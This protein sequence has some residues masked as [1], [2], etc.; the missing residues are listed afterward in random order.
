MNSPYKTLNFFYLND[1]PFLPL[2][3]RGNA[4][5]CRIGLSKQLIFIPK[6]YFNDDLTLKDNIDLRWFLNKKDIKH[7]IELYKEETNE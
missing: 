3:K 2:S 4:I 5:N 7:K 1:I 6:R